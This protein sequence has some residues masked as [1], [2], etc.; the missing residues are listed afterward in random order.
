MGPGVDV[1]GLLVRVLPEADS[2]TQEL[3]EGTDDLLIE[4]AEVDEAS[5]ALL[6]PDTAPEGAKGLGVLVGQLLAQVTTVSGLRA[7]V[8]AVQAWASRRNRTVE[9]SIDGDVLKMAGV[10]TQQQEKII[11]AWDRSCH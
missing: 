9:I 6:T 10:S 5:V 1:T 7:V 3:A 11:D 8:S 2:D 4:L